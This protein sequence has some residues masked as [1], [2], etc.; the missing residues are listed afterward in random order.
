[1]FLAGRP[2][3]QDLLGGQGLDGLSYGVGVGGQHL[4]QTGRLYLPSL[5]GERWGMAIAGA[6]VGAAGASEGAS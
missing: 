1:M 5:P 3:D 6:D 4:L 2:C